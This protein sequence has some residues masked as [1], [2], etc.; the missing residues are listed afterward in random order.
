MHKESRVEYRSDGTINNTV[1]IIVGKDKPVDVGLS[2]FGLKID[3]KQRDYYLTPT[4]TT[5]LRHAM[6]ARA[7]NM[8]IPLDFLA[9]T[10]DISIG[11][12]KAQV[13]HLRQKLQN[14]SIEVEA[15]D[16]GLG[17]CLFKKGEERVLFNQ[18]GAIDKT[19]FFL[20][21]KRLSIKME[22]SGEIFGFSKDETILLDSLDYKGKSGYS[23]V[24]RYN[25]FAKEYGLKKKITYHELKVL[26][27]NIRKIT[28]QFGIN[29]I[30]SSRSEGYRIFDPNRPPKTQP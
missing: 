18:F 25:I 11:N 22:D 16:A 2:T 29:L 17:Y 19:T 24:Q 14:S 5:I 3:G 6:T 30:D 15:S 21:R 4:Q 7:I 26:V 28:K 27:F 20:D 10:M 9:R 23:M 1:S 12:L 13:S 8:W